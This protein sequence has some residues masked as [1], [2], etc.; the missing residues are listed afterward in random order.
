[1]K[2]LLIDISD[3][4]ITRKQKLKK[5][6]ERYKSILS[7]HESIEYKFDMHSGTKIRDVM[8][9]FDKDSNNTYI[10][11]IYS[12]GSKKFPMHL[13]CLNLNTN[14]EETLLRAK[15]IKLYKSSNWN[16]FLY[17][18]DDETSISRIKY[19]KDKINICNSLDNLFDY[20][21][22]TKGNYQMPELNINQIQERIENMDQY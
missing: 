8:S 17:K 2:H 9:Y 10:L 19:V 16:V 22:G 21:C 12:D 13:R 11:Y 18:K 3:N 20:W 14:E 4:V 7:S 6:E 1:M 5:L 15:F